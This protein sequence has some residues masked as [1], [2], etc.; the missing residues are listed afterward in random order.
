MRHSRHD[1]GLHPVP[2]RRWWVRSNCG[3]WRCPACGPKKKAETLKTI[4]HGAKTGLAARPGQPLRF[5]TLTYGADKD[6][7]FDR[8]DDVIASSEDWRRLVQTLRR[9][10]RQLEYVRVLERTKRGRI[11]IHAITWG[12]WLPKCTDAGRRKRHMPY[13]PGS[14]SPCYCTDAGGRPCIQKAAHDAGFGWVDVRKIRSSA[15][16]ASY[17]AKYLAKQSADNWPRHA[18]RVSFSRRFADGLT[19]GAVHAAWVAEVRRRL[20]ELGELEEI[21]AG[22]LWRYHPRS[23]LSNTRAPPR[24]WLAR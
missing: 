16:A 14:G 18:R 20:A 8:H 13:G 21:P 1:G 7:S 4:R 2:V 6:R 10:G 22:V 9:Q 17:V 15:A 11:H 24:P 19:L 3:M 5:I 12:D 23:E